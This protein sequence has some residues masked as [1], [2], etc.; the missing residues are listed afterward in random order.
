MWEKPPRGRR[1]GAR[2]R[3]PSWPAR[4]SRIGGW[5]ARFSA[6]RS[7]FAAAFIFRRAGLDAD[8][9]PGAVLRG[10]LDGVFHPGEFLELGVQRLE[11]GGSLVQQD[12]RVHFLADRGVRADQDAFPALDAQVRFPYRDLQGNVAF[13]PARGSGW[14]GPIRGHRAHR[15]GI[16]LKCQDRPDHLLYV[17]RC[18]DG[19]PAAPVNQPVRRGRKPDLLQVGKGRIDGLEVLLDDRVP[20]LAV[21]LL[22]ALLDLGDG[23]LARQY[24]ADGEKAGL[25]DGVDPPAHP[26]LLGDLVGIDDVQPQPLCEDRTLYLAGQLVPDLLGTVDAV[27]QEHP[28]RGGVLEHVQPLE[29][30][31]LVAGHKVSIALADQVRSADRAAARSAG[32]RWSPTPISSNR[33]QK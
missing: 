1:P 7:P 25:H 10:R 9:A 4:V 15:D 21:G 27:E 20:A 31:E 13:L 16:A 6:L 30:G 29:E 23:L 28:A 19:H 32:G 12:R 5:G 14:V 11:P 3:S 26:G 17:A 2:G 8:A 33:R 22:D 18:A 24:P